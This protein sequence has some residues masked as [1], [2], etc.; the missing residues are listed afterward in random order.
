MTRRTGPH[1]LYAHFHPVGGGPL[2]ARSYEALLALLGQVTPVVQALPPD[3]ALADVGG[4]L[5]YFGRDATG[6][7]TLI[8]VRA[9]AR[10]GADCTIGVAGNPLLARMAAH[11]GPSGA[12]R[13]V[14]DEP[15]A[16]AAFLARKPVAAL[17][18]VGPA[19][20]RRL[21]SYG[22]DSAGRVAAAPLGT[23][24]RILGAAAGR[25]I[26][27]QAH[28]IDPARVTPNAPA[29]SVGGERHF[30]RD[31]LDPVRH[32]AALLSL[33]EELGAR[34]RATGQVTRSLTLTVRYADR[35]TTVRARALAEPTGHGVPLAAAGYR[36]YES[37]GLQ[38]A[39][40]RALSLRAEGLAPAEG[41]PRQLTLDQADDKA[42]RIEEAVD[43]ARVRFG[44]RA[45][46]LAA[47]A[48]AA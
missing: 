3:A 10:Y 29:R 42:R 24:Q 33:T 30:G 45:A 1:V 18:G 36:L 43:R 22:L 12:V 5:R 26:H 13:T 31:E 20:A 48:G 19:T 23:L 38:R 2:G 16:V 14:P 37:L 27:E 44:P 6:L 7:A 40:V 4:A 46:C 28:G 11:D 8:R 34:L 21:C 41:A 32:R 15:E 35:S 47:T 39:R 9:L 17:H 25:R